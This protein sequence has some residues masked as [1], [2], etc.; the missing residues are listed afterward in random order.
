VQRSEMRGALMISV[1]PV[2]AVKWLVPRL[3]QF[4]DAHPD[5][6]VR[7]SAR[8]T[9]I[10]FRRDA[11]D[12]A[13]RL[14]RGTYPGLDSTKL[15]D[16]TLTPM[17]GP[18]LLA[19]DAPLRA[20]EDLRHHVLLHDDSLEYDPSA[21]NW[22]SWLKAAGA[23][24]VD[25]GRGPHFSHPDHSLQAAIDGA[26]VVLGWRHLA[27]ADLAAGRLIAPF[28]LALPMDLGFYFVCPEAQVDQPKVVLFREWLLQEVG[29]A[30]LEIPKEIP[31]GA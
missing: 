5:I 14:G 25:P 31:G 1:A 19:G 7:I 21:P 9:V 12:A 6:D 8:L 23:T 27:A 20:P 28:D 30:I 18:R 4:N 17:C 15:F 3:E 22:S 2:F 16:E 26:G 10:D 24:D 13:I 11:F 29:R